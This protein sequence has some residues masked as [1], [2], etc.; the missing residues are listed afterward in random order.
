MLEQAII[1]ADALRDTAL[2]NAE[3]QVIEK[4][5]DEIREAVGNLLEQP[6]D[7][8]ADLGADPAAEG[9]EGAAETGEEPGMEADAENLLDST[10]AAAHE[11]ENLCPCPDKG[12]VV[13]IDLN[14]MAS[15]L[16]DKDDEL[17][18]HEV[19]ASQIT[20]PD[21]EDRNSEELRYRLGS[22]E[23][24]LSTLLGDM[25]DPIHGDQPN[26]YQESVEDDELDKIIEKLTVDIEP[27]LTG[28]AGRPEKDIEV[29]EQ[30][31]LAALQ[32]EEAKEDREAMKAA[33][34][35]LQEAKENLQNTN[36]KLAERNQK[37]E[38]ISMQLRDRLVE[39]NLSN[40]RLLYTNKVLG[41][42]SLNGRQ[43]TKIVEAISKAES[44]EEAKTIF[45]TLQSTVGPVRKASPK[46]LSEAVNRNS[47][48]ILPRARKDSPKNPVMNRWKTLAGI[49]AD[50]KD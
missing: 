50:K 45:E 14:D 26:M 41:S 32:D 21:S 33:V 22:L 25:S 47:S 30:E 39:S 46:S 27:Q 28:W 18:P 3:A 24:K 34:D 20:S 1:D 13:T 15:K 35:A 17:E 23:D 10:P 48:T 43:K 4:Y 40:A 7:P 36:N 8:L 9:G 31:I 16:D 12:D 42:N 2:K 11:G 19:V 49:S 5:S 29:S 37:L 44:V 38:D 6:E